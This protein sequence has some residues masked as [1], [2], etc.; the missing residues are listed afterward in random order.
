MNFIT[1]SLDDQWIV[2]RL[3]QHDNCKVYIE[4]LEDEVVLCCDDCQEII[5]NFFRKGVLD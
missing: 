1:E 3:V 5:V 2:D 4:I